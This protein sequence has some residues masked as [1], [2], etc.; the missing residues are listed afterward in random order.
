MA[1]YGPIT[2]GARL[3]YLDFRAFQA[4]IY[5]KSTVVLFLLADLIG[6]E[7][8]DRGLC[9]FQASSAYRPSGR[10]SSSGPW[11]KPRPFAP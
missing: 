1:D 10:G 2:L 6:E 5:G 4:I 9:A 11:R 8:L 3:S 7:A